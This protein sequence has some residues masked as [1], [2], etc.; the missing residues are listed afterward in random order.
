MSNEIIRASTCKTILFN[1]KAR[2]F[3]AWV[4]KRRYETDRPRACGRFLLHTHKET[5][6]TRT[7]MHIFLFSYYLQPNYKHE[8]C[9]VISFLSQTERLAE[10]EREKE[11]HDASQIFPRASALSLRLISFFLSPRRRIRKK[12]L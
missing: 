6:V 8:R 5:R 10:R 7:L 11:T 4:M 9:A 12:K 2:R 1:V 3:R